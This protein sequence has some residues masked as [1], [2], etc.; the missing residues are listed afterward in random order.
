MTYQ[1]AAARPRKSTARKSTRRPRCERRGGGFAAVSA[2]Q[3]PARGWCRLRGVSRCSSRSCEPPFGCRR[4]WRP[5]SLPRRPWSRRSRWARKTA[6]AVERPIV[7]R[8]E[9]V[10]PE[11][12]E[13][14]RADHAID[15]RARHRRDGIRRGRCRGGEWPRSGRSRGGRRCRDKSGRAPGSFR[16]RR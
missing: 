10:L 12:G 7:M 8:A 1:A 6:G 3:R 13:Q 11:G 15:R 2:V 9:R 5:A 16:P 4:R 14:E